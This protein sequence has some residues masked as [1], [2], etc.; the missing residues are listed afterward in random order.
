[1]NR[2]IQCGTMPACFSPDF[3]FRPAKHCLKDL[4]QHADEIPVAAGEFSA[5]FLHNSVCSIASEPRGRFKGSLIRNEMLS[6]PSS[7]NPL[8]NYVSDQA[9]Q[10][11]RTASLFLRAF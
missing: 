11:G 6:S 2:I 4:G 3:R 10:F 8:L 9:V 7:M 5:G 1:M